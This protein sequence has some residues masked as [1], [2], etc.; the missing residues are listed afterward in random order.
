MTKTILRWRGDDKNINFE[1]FRRDVGNGAVTDHQ[2]VELISRNSWRQVSVVI[3]A[4]E[5]ICIVK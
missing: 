1:L 3:A 2:A 5:S 4:V